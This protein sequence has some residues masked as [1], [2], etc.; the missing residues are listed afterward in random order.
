M[1][2]STPVLGSAGEWVELR[3]AVRYDGA[4]TELWF[5]ADVPQADVDNG[6]EPFLS[7]CLLPAMRAGVALRTD[8][9][10]SPLFLANQSRIQAQFQAW[11]PALRIIEVL[12]PL[13][14]DA[15][16]GA[17]RR[18]AS[19]FSGGVDS[20][21][22]ALARRDEIDDLVFVHGFDIPVADAELY[23][24]AQAR[25]RQA[26]ESMGKTLVRVSTN[27]REFSDPLADW[28]CHQHGPALGAVAQW[29][30]PRCGTF[31]IPGEYFPDEPAAWL[32][33]SQP[34][35]DPLFSTERV[36]IVHDGYRP[37]RVRKLE[38]ILGEPCVRATLRVC[39]ENRDGAYNCGRCSKCLRNMAAIHSCGRLDECATFPRELDLEALAHLSIEKS[40][41]RRLVEEVFHKIS[42]DKS[43]PALALA[44]RRCL[45]RD[46]RRRCFSG[47][48]G[49][50][51]FSR[52]GAPA[53]ARMKIL[54]TGSN[55]VIGTVV[56]KGLTDFSL[57]CFDLPNGDV[58]D[59]DRLVTASRG[60]EAIVHLAWDTRT[61]HWM[62]E[63]P[64]ESST[65]MAAHVYE[66]ARL[67]GVA[68]VV[69]ASS[70]QADDYERPL[71]IPM[72]PYASPRPRNPYGESKARIEAMARDYAGK[73]L[74]IACI[75]FG[76]VRADN[77]VPDIPGGATRFL[78][79]GD[80]C[81]LVRA[82]IEGVNDTRRAGKPRGFPPYLSI[83]YGVSRGGE[84]LFSTDNPYDWR[85][86]DRTEDFMNP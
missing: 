76:A 4:T 44:L 1:I 6:I 53:R 47:W 10:V 12:A 82:C 11:D 86:R 29:L 55:G 16:T 78:S 9:P 74:E 7:A 15:P 45:A 30:A 43:D 18:T 71:S 65:R 28:G 17:G 83:L 19:F 21:H 46:R 77:L 8:S 56:R 32:R 54:I 20:F 70:V 61:E 25:I 38:A 67:N 34:R 81:A 22:T 58:L 63:T 79:H 23:E 26:A 40:E 48:A 80:C 52:V 3:S 69:M 2:L 72:N 33:G 36:G 42:T 31:F 39:W 60:C 49:R 84:N 13:R 85:P 75:R 73:G 24:A 59:F 57:V 37:T 35:T 5:R 64:S 51:P 50:I 14:V 68:R 41:W 27:L 62:S 66:A